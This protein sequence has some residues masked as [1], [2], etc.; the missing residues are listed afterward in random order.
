M[1]SIKIGREERLLR[2]AEPHWIT[3]QINDRLRDGLVVCVVIIIN[4]PDVDLC[5]ATPAC[6]RGGGGRTRPLTAREIEIVAL[7][8]RHGLNEAEFAAGSVVAFVKQALQRI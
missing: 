1:S 6:G 7:W 3:H 2:N 8:T 4:E 5:L